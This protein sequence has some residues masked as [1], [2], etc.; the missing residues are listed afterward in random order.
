[1]ARA[2]ALGR[3]MSARRRAACL[4]PPAAEV[5]G[6]EMALLRRRLRLG[7]AAMLGADL[8]LRAPLGVG[9]PILLG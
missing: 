9:R 8:R 2:A 4:R 6:R 7:R 5:F 3:G 1:M